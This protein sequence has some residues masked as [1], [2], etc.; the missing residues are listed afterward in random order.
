MKAIFFVVEPSGKPLAR[1]ARAL[2]LRL[3]KTFV[4][5]T[6]SIADMRRAY[7]MGGQ[8]GEVKSSHVSRLM[9]GI[10][11]DLFYLYKKVSGFILWRTHIVF[12]L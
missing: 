2:Q 7:E 11:S 6:F 4:A 12:L 8:L 9:L 5:D 1:L 10:E 3:L